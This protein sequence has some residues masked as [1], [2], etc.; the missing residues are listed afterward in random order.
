MVAYAYA[1]Q[2]SPEVEKLAVMDAFLPGVAGSGT[3]TLWP[4]ARKRSAHCN[5][6]G[7]SPR[8]VWKTMIS[9]VVKTRLPYPVRYSQFEHTFSV[10]LSPGSTMPL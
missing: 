4:A 7:L 9:L 6:P 5:S 2:F 3:W 8:A 1:A 10:P